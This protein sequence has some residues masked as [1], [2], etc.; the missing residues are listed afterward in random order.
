MSTIMGEE[1]GDRK[2]PES[3]G[4]ARILEEM[5]QVPNETNIESEKQTTTMNYS[6]NAESSFL[7]YANMLETINEITTK[8]KKRIGQRKKTMP[9]ISIVPNYKGNNILRAKDFDREKEKN[10]TKIREKVNNST[11]NKEDKRLIWY[12]DPITFTNEWPSTTRETMRCFHINHNGINYHNDYLEWEMSLAY[13]LDMQVDIFGI[14]EANLDFHNPIVKDEFIQRGKFFDSYMHMSVSSSLQKVGKTPFKMGGTV[15]GVNGCWSGRVERSGSDVLGRWSY[16]SLRTK[17]NKLINI[18]TTYLPGKATST[19][20]ESTIYSQMELDLLQSKKQLLDPR[21]EIL[22]SLKKFLQKEH[23]IGNKNIL[24]GDV[25]DN[26]SDKKSEIRRFLKEVDMEPSYLARHGDD[27]TLPATH[28]RGSTCIDL[29]A[30]TIGLPEGTIRRVGYAPFY[31]NIYTDH[32]GIYVDLDIQKLFSS[33]R[34]DST[35]SIFKRFTTRHIPKCEKYLKKLEELLEESKMFQQI[36]KLE[37]DFKNTATNKDGSKPQEVLIRRCKTLFEK[38]SQFMICSEK[39]SG[40]LPY[41]DGFP[42]S[43]KLRAAAFQVVRLKK[44]LRLVSLGIL[45]GD[46]EERKNA[47]L[48]LRKAMEKLRDAQKSSHMLRQEFLSHL[49]EKRS[50]QWKMDTSEALE[51]IR[52]SEKSQQMHRKHRRFMKPG[53]MGTLRSLMIPAPIT[54]IKNNVKDPK[55]YMEIS[56][57]DTMFDVLLRKNF[58]HLLLSQSSMFSKGPILDKCG[59]YGEE[60]GI[61]DLLN[62]LLDCEEMGKAYPEFGN[63][64]VEFLRALRIKKDKNGK[65]PEPFKWT[66]GVEQY[67]EVFNHTKEATACGPSGLHMSHWKAACEREGI[68]RIHAFFIWAAF[69]YGFTY[70]RWESSWHCMIQKMRQPLLQ[71]LRIVQLFEG[72]FNA[73]LKYLIGRKLM[74]HMNDKK[75]HDPE[76]FG[77]RS[78]KTAPEALINLQLLFDHCRMWKKPVGCIF[79]DAIGCYDRIV[80]ILCETSMINK[81]CPAGIAKCHTLTQ[82]NMVHRIRI[83]TGISRGAISFKKEK[84]T[85]QENSHIISIKGKTGGIGQGGGGG[86]MAWISVINI[87]IEAYRTLCKGARAS[88]ICALYSLTYWIVSY[89]DDNTL[90]QT[91]DD[92]KE[93]KVMIKNMTNNLRSWQRLLQLTG[94]DIDLEKSQWCL[95]SWSYDKI[96]GLPLLRSNDQSRGELKMTSPINSG[97]TPEKLQRLEPGEADR[98]LGVRLPMDGSMMIEYKHREKQTKEF[99]QRLMN[100]P[101]SHYDAYIIYE[102][103][104]RSMIRYPL[105]LTHFTETQCHNLQRPVIAALLPK[106][107]LNRNMPRAVIYGPM[108]LGGREI[109]DLRIEQVTCQW[110]AT[111]GHL[112]RGDR[113]GVGLRLT[114]HDHQCIIGSE[115]LFLNLNPNKYNYGITNTRW[116]FHWEKI[117]ESQLSAEFYDTWLPKKKRAN[118]VNLMDTATE[119]SI[120]TGSKWRL[121]EHINMCRMYLNVFYISELSIDGKSVDPGYLDGSKIRTQMELSIPTMQKPTPSQWRIWKSFIYRNFL[122][123]GI[124]I[125]PHL[126]GERTTEYPATKKDTEA[127]KIVSLY[128]S[129][130]TIEEI[131]EKFPTELHQMIGNF[132]LPTDEGLRLSESI[133]EGECIGASDGS[134]WKGFN[135]VRGGFGYV[136]CQSGSDEGNIHGIGISPMCDEMSSQTSEHQGLIGLICIIHAVSIK[137]LLRKEECWGSIVIYIDN[138]NVVKRANTVQTPF[139]IG[140]Y[141]IPDQDLWALTTEL[142]DSLPINVEFK[143]IKGHG[144]TNDRGEVIHGPFSRSVQLNIWTDKLAS[145]GLKQSEG[146]DIQK[147]PFSTT[148]VLLKTQDGLVIQN[149]RRFLLREKNGEELLDY[150]RVKKGWHS[151]IF[152]KI[153]WEAIDSLLRRADPIKKNRI[154]QVMHDWQNIGRQKGKFRDARLLKKAEHPLQPTIE[155]KTIHLC[156]N[157]CG[158]VEDHL[159][160][161]KCADKAMVIERTKLRLDAIKRLK[162]LRTNDYICSIINTVLRRI[163]NNE[164]IIFDTTNYSTEDEQ[165]MLPAILGQEEIGWENLLKGFMHNGWAQAQRIH[166]KTRGLTSRYFSTARWKRMFLTILLDYGNECWKLRNEALHGTSTKEGRKVRR[167]RLL[168]QVKQLYTHKQELKGSKYRLIFKMSLPQRLKSGIQSLTLW[169]GKAEEVL[170]LHREEA[171]KNTIS[172]WL[173]CR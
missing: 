154:I 32:R 92:E 110:D 100:A 80:P 71:K 99:A 14:T 77:S 7:Q 111:R 55:T 124:N 153:D 67:K 144:D 16:T 31:T 2:N 93:T 131:L 132:T 109:M 98:I 13:L 82:K 135:E 147:Q 30:T 1:S 62:G 17:K 151:R 42:D 171:D 81:G 51:I 12:G 37:N 15:T 115:K 114:L 155:E 22:N 86:P 143:W 28:D 113:A 76:T 158:E 104:Y 134:M 8:R 118:D 169:I 140:D 64:G 46:E 49:A 159:H 79:N 5:M 170:R 162:R 20:G 105:S 4:A 120:I 41:K 122:S 102:C 44:Y 69:E 160:Y 68:A 61:E 91:F 74:Q 35:R 54:G 75:L 133:V 85:I 103:R 90:V 53:N 57:S 60:Q 149:L 156:P 129:D 73:G 83:S 138:K 136:L 141:Q 11:E 78:G 39:N 145:E 95:L 108:S 101:I 84:E 94:G 112:C 50:R 152:N 9:N 168:D 123:P 167:K 146:S 126:Q 139:N 47:K 45:D 40:P 27:A 38:V 117:W 70:P 89:V 65:K 34:P 66:F 33:T 142:V 121:L 173:G 128:G 58:N 116:K 119:D 23:E 48:D 63:E 166:Y 96:W 19:R 24:M 107:G 172:R 72:D 157:G 25:N 21:K 29:V 18:I 150:Y 137:Y 127:E 165:N 3:V 88:D 130:G 36:N 106:M 163:S 6:S 43:P 125:N 26:V 148:N 10:E 97:G 56:D 164:D 87:M 52:E 161:V 59:W